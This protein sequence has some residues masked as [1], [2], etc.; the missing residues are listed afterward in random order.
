MLHYLHNF[1][2]TNNE[3]KGVNTYTNPFFFFKQFGQTL[4]DGEKLKWGWTLLQHTLEIW[5]NHNGIRD[6]SGVNSWAPFILYLY[7]I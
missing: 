5:Q 1:S 6:P 7:G 4:Q 3:D 2:S